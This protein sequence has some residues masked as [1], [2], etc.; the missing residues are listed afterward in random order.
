MCVIKREPI[1]LNLIK[2]LFQ[3]GTNSARGVG[4]REPIRYQPNKYCP[5][6]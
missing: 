2:Y 6:A 1:R 5:L 3:T 4:A